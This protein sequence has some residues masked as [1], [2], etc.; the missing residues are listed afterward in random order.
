MRG[1]QKSSS[2]SEVVPS[3]FKDNKTRA[4]DL[5]PWPKSLE[6]LTVDELARYRRRRVPD[7]PKDTLGSRNH[8]DKDN[9][10]EN[11]STEYRRAFRATSEESLLRVDD[12]RTCA[13]DFGGSFSI[14]AIKSPEINANDKSMEAIDI[15]RVPDLS[16]PSPIRR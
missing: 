12:L 4:R 3:K 7:S 9:E 5:L 13:Q 10:F 11:L 1:T 14:E 2:D 8:G 15:S 16:R 6:T